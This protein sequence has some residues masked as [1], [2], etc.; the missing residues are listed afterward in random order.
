MY[1]SVVDNLLIGDLDV[2]RNSDLLQKLKVKYVLSV[3]PMKQEDIVFLS[4]CAIISKVIPILD[5]E[6]E[7][8]SQYF[9][10][11]S[12]F[13]HSGITA[14]S[15]SSTFDVLEESACGQ[16]S[17]H[18]GGVVLVHCF[19]GIS[20]SSTAVISYLMIQLGFSLDDSLEILERAHP[21]GHPNEG[22]L[23]QLRQL[24]LRLHPPM[25]PR[26]IRCKICGKHLLYEHETIQH[27]PD[28]AKKSFSYKKTKKDFKSPNHQA[29]SST[30]VTGS[31]AAASKQKQLKEMKGSSSDSKGCSKIFLLDRMDWIVDNEMKELE[32]VLNCPK[33]KAKIGG[34]RWDGEQCSCGCWVRPSIH[35]HKAKVDILSISL[36][37]L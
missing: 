37:S 12:D 29:T 34:Y 5:D 13:I 24:Q 26:S 3:C 28:H 17:R 6:A 21:E 31:A 7:N 22:F 32:G 1:H 18:D 2:V 35:V 15:A 27:D 19:S 20:R 16:K 33:C 36:K 10:E 30:V 8:F 23:N 14:A 4:S 11:C 9:Q 25:Y